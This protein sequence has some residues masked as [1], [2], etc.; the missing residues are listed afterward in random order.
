MEGVLCRDAEILFARTALLNALEDLVHAGAEF[1]GDV[2]LEM[3]L[4]YAKKLQAAGHFATQVMRGVLQGGDGLLGV[5]AFIDADADQG[6]ALIG[7]DVDGGDS[8]RGDARVG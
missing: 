4:G 3:Q 5:G 1:G 6:V 2:G 7:S 8:G